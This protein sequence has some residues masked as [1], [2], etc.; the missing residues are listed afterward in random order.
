MIDLH[1]H[2]LFGLDD[3][4]DTLDTSVE[5]ARMAV[6]DGVT[7]MA[8][9]P[10]VLPGRYPNSSATILPAV[11]AFQSVLQA[12]GIPLTLVPGADVHIAWDL[13]AKLA[14]NEIPT[15]NR[16]R[17][18]LLEP[19]H[20][21]LPPRL[22][23]LVRRLLRCGFIPIITHPERLG[24]ITRHYDIVRR[25]NA[26]GCPLQITA[27]SLLGRFGSEAKEAAIR[28]LDDGLDCFVA[29]DAHGTGR[30]NPVMSH[31]MR[32]VAERWGEDAAD[33]MFVTI[34]GIILANG[35]LPISPEK[36][37]LRRPVR[38]HREGMKKLVELLRAGH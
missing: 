20:Q 37:E 17:Y 15:L 7:H 26:I 6:A 28:I 8:C 1:S 14:K 13:P 2:I 5:M 9:T 36:R 29:S 23:D 12:C 16:T 21:F 31:A 34:P 19:P 24:W 10:H 4:A 11:A 18:F 3:G 35:D 22:E 32:I 25:L 33:N 27:D 38:P 30:R